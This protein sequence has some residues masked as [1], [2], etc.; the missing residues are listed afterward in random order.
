MQRIGAPQLLRRTN[1]DSVRKVPQKRLC[2]FARRLHFFDRADRCARIAHATPCGGGQRLHR[3]R[4]P[5]NALAKRFVPFHRR[6]RQ[7]RK[8][9]FGGQ[10]PFVGGNILRRAQRSHLS[11]VQRTAARAGDTVCS[12]AL[13]DRKQ[14][15]HTRLPPK[16]DGDA[17]VVVLG[18]FTVLMGEKVEP[19]KE[20]IEQRAKYAVNLDY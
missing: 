4:T 7:V 13:A 11:R 15:P 2:L 19:R 9:F 17:A 18:T 16:V 20:F 10:L 6:C 1:A 8:G 14:S 5:Q 3:V 12:R